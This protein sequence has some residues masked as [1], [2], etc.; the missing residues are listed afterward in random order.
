MIRPKWLGHPNINWN[1]HPKCWGL[2]L[3]IL[4]VYLFVVAHGVAI[5]ASFQRH[6][7][8][9]AAEA[10]GGSVLPGVSPDRQGGLLLKE[11]TP[12]NKIILG[13]PSISVLSRGPSFQETMQNPQKQRSLKERCLKRMGNQ[14]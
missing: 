3:S 11:K 8:D 12:G 10:A 1:I 5:L 13:V 7:A 6:G 9:A 14:P 4:P 2:A